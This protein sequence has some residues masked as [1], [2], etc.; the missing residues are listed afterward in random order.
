MKK[1]VLA[2][3]GLLLMIVLPYAIGFWWVNH[4]ADEEIAKAAKQFKAAGLPWEAKDLTPETIPENE[5]AREAILA[6]R[7]NRA[8]KD[9]DTKFA[10]ALEKNDLTQC[11]QLMQE[12][13][14]PLKAAEKVATYRKVDF[15]RDWD[16]GM[17]VL[18]PEYAEM[19]P[20][21]RLLVFR[22]DYESRAGKL[23]DALKD[24]ERGWQ[25]GELCCQDPVQ[26]AVLVTVAER[27]IVL[28]GYETV[29]ADLAKDPASLKMIGESLNRLPNPQLSSSEAVKG[30]LYGVIATYRN[31]KVLSPKFNLVN[32]NE[33]KRTGGPSTFTA[34]SSFAKF[35][36]R[37]IASQ[38][39]RSKAT[40]P[41]IVN[42]QLGD[43]LDE[44]DSFFSR[45]IRGALDFS[46][47]FGG[48]RFNGS[49]NAVTQSLAK[50][51]ATKQLTQALLT[52]TLTGKYP[53]A[54]TLVDPFNSGK[55]LKILVT[56][57]SVR[58]YS[59]G[60]NRID[61]GG[62]ISSE[63]RGSGDTS[64]DV[65]VAYPPIKVKNRF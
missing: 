41:L 60:Q 50:Y 6:L 59:I 16:Q 8:P 1:L 11:G 12:V 24:L 64:G 44:A 27:A 37:V 7:K 19:K 51:L 33:L 23:V 46:S 57:D 38:A 3:T 39:S 26:I 62:R 9:W 53:T 21:V 29:L 58:V 49:T 31:L 48:S 28:R 61:D 32:P 65:V 34:K 47:G 52:H 2:F 36:N 63:L 22:A 56:G 20:A 42:Q 40:D 45:S 25:I 4:K 43:A 5:N 15:K 54:S 30:E 17:A 55:M 10:S 35:C 13:E 14:G 18:L